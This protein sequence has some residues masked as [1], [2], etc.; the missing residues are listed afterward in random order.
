MDTAD[1]SV[2]VVGGGAAGVQASLDLANMG[3]SVHLIEKS[4]AIGE[5]IVY[6]DLI[7]RSDF[8]I[9]PLYPKMVECARHPRIVLH[10]CSEV[11]GFKR[12]PEGF[13][14]K[15]LENPRYVKAEKCI[16]CQACSDKCPSKVRNEMDS[17]KSTRKAIYMPLPESVPRIVAIDAKNCHFF[18][19]KICRVCEKFCTSG[20]ID[21]DQGSHET[22][23]NVARIV[24]A[25]TLDLKD[26]SIFPETKDVGIYRCK[27]PPVCKP[28]DWQAATKL[29]AAAASAVCQDMTG[30]TGVPESNRR[31][32]PAPRG[33]VAVVDPAKCDACGACESLCASR[34]PQVSADG[35]QKVCRID[36]LLCEGCGTCVAGCP[37]FAIT[38]ENS[39]DDEI[40]DRV[41][42]V[43][44]GSG[45]TG[46]PEILMFACKYCGFPISERTGAWKSGYPQNIKVVSLPC[47][48]RLD[49]FMV[50]E[51]LRYG[52]DGII[53]SGCRPGYCHYLVGNRIAE[54]RYKILEAAMDTLEAGSSRVRLQWIS[55]SESKSF[56][57]FV[58]E[59]TERLQALGPNPMKMQSASVG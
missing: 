21:F 53:I 2:M 54:Q 55:P 34:A 58:K 45:D 38:L 31:Q 5:R 41:K 8:T 1:K 3:L 26:A 28:E 7:S 16:G 14:V 13:S 59:M 57:A 32:I 15:I 42:A 10:L 46:E 25:P 11:M 51:A 43:L 27:Y 35:G 29:G 22:E 50:A 20:A 18:T 52:A 56:L 39:A 37:R 12:N 36:P 6:R 47:S 48:G 40:L 19:K 23:I 49:P 24:V 44:N 33:A 17:G 4:P 30:A 9:T